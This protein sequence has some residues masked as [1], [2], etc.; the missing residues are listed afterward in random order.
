MPKVGIANAHEA[1][2]QEG[3][4]LTPGKD[5]NERYNAINEEQI[6]VSPEENY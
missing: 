5:D 3:S 6:E 4:S 2:D 1:K